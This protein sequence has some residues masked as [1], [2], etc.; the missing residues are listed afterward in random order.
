V[1]SLTAGLRRPP[2]TIETGLYTN[3][4]ALEH[5]GQPQRME[6]PSGALP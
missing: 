3:A 2:Y 1:F 5:L 6:V 4:P